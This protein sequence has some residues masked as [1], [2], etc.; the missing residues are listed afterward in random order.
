MTRVKQ[1]LANYLM[2]FSSASTLLCC[3]LPTFRRC[4]GRTCEQCS[5]PHLD[6]RKQTLGFQRG[7]NPSFFQWPIDVA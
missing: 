6:L 4:D 7:G 3:A 1:G 5:R 2:L